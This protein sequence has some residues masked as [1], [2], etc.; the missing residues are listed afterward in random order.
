MR[1]ETKDAAERRYTGLVTGINDIDPVRWPGSK[2][3]CLLVRWDDDLE[4]NRHNRVSP[5]E[6]EPLGPVSSCSSLSVPGLKENTRTT[7]PSSKPDFPVPNGTGF[8][9]FGNL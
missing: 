3:R 1:F 8:S 4:T 7:L 5:W 6:I 9:D 2:W